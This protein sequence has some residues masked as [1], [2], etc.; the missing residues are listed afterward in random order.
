MR[1][2]DRYALASFFRIWIIAFLCLGGL[3]VIIDLFSNLDDFLAYRDHPGGAARVMYEYYVARLVVFWDRSS[4]VLALLAALYVLARMQHANE[5]TALEA[6][7]V[8]RWRIGCPF[9][10]A[11]VA[12]SL[13]GAAGRETVVPRL[14][15]SLS[16]RPQD[17]YRQ[18]AEQLLPRYDNQTDIYLQGRAIQVQQHRIEQPSFRLPSALA[19]LGRELAAQYATYHPEDQLHPAGYLLQGVTEPSD[20]DRLPSQTVKGRIVV[21]TPADTPWLQPGQCF[22]VSRVEPEQLTANDA[23]RRYASTRQLVRALHNPSLDYG[24]DVRVTVHLRILQPVLDLL[25]FLVG[26]PIVFLRRSGNVF[27]AVGQAVVTVAGY[28]ALLL[29]CQAMGNH[30]LIRPALAAWLPAM[31]LAPLAAWNLLGAFGTRR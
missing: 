31:V 14:R 27:W 13:L 24:A 10:L 15:D 12:L 20:L 3:Y 9:V 21:F 16:R 22:V 29:A 23:W 7:G 19:A 2:F 11:A 4:A 1:L 25:V 26:M 5:I 18:T 28:F 17:W 8:A 30:Y 6:A